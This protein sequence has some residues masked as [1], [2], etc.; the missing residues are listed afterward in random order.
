[1]LD[2]GVDSFET[3]EPAHFARIAALDPEVVIFGSGARLRFAH[4]RL[5]TAL[6]ER[7]IGVE[8]MDTAAAARTYNVLVTEGRRVVGALLPLALPSPYSQG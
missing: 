7:R 8:C 2:W 4:P 6:I 3:L 5:L 1:V